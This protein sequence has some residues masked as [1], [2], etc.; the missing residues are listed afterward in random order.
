MQNY[1]QKTA[2]EIEKNTL[3]FFSVKILKKNAKV[4]DLNN[5]GDV[6][7]NFGNVSKKALIRLF[8]NDLTYYLNQMEK[9]NEVKSTK[10]TTLNSEGGDKVYFYD[11]FKKEEQL[12]SELI[13]YFPYYLNESKIKYGNIT[14]NPLNKSLSLPFILEKEEQNIKFET[15]VYAIKSYEL[16]TFDFK[17]NF[18]KL[19]VF[20]V[21][22]LYTLENIIKNPL[23][24]IVIYVNNVG[25]NT[26]VRG[27][28]KE[29]DVTEV[30]GKA[31]VFKSE[32][33][34]KYNAKYA[35]TLKNKHTLNSFKEPYVEAERRAVDVK[36]R[37]NSKRGL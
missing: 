24:C 29:P 37:I 3:G 10:I 31:L 19:P 6:I 12:K 28:Y 35:S 20:V 30:K 34:N 9:N 25:R 17:Q 14:V 32:Y 36:S 7:L 8:S 4:L 21:D 26:E 15:E 2:E 22:E 27:I 11:E 23:N 33:V 13:S 18:E 1:E 16:N 5:L